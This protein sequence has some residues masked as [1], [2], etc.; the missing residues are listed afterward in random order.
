VYCRSALCSKPSNG[1]DC[2]FVSVLESNF[3]RLCTWTI[4]YVGIQVPVELSYS[5]A[6]SIDCYGVAYSSRSPPP[7]LPFVGN[8]GGLLDVCDLRFISFVFFFFEAR[9]GT[10]A[11]LISPR[12]CTRPPSNSVLAKLLGLSLFEFSVAAQPR[13]DCCVNKES[14][15]VRHSIGDDSATIESNVGLVKQTY[16]VTPVQSASL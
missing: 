2:T 3:R 12:R 16:F 10:S 9:I 11:C 5:T 14:R 13:A 4:T 1:Q 7:F 6:R 8:N 15:T